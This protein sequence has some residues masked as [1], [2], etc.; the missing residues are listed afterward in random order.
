LDRADTRDRTTL[1][2][3]VEAG[4]AELIRAL[5]VLTQSG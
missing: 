5:A 1:R 2:Q 3:A 4:V